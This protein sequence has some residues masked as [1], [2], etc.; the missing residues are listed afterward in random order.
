MDYTWDV[1]YLF[2]WAS[3][4]IN[5]TIICACVPT[6]RPLMMV[7]AGKRLARDS[8]PY[9]NDTRNSY[10][11]K[12]TTQKGSKPGVSLSAREVD[13]SMKDDHSGCSEH[14]ALTAAS[15]RIKQTT[16]IEQHWETV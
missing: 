8:D 5:V 9:S 10:S 13:G 6:L 16:E 12:R 11:L 2:F 4:E 1:L 15:Q 14:T 7:L 3:I